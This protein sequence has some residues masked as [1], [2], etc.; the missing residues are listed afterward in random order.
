MRKLANRDAG[1]PKTLDAIVAPGRISALRATIEKLKLEKLDLETALLTSNEHNDYLQDHLYRISTSLAAEVRERQVVE[2][3]LQQVLQEVAEENV[4]LENLVQI[5]IDQGDASAEE[6]A[7]ARIDGLTQIAN[8]RRFDEYLWHEWGRHRQA[9]QPIS[10]LICDV[11]HFKL[12]NDTYGHQAGD[13]CLR[14]VAKAM[15]LCVRRNADVV[16]RYGG[17]EFAMVLPETDLQGAVQVANRVR[18]ALELAALSYA[19][20][21]VSDKV[22]LSIG[23]ACRIPDPQGTAGPQVLL[24]EADRFLY[25]AKHH[26]RN[27]VGHPGQK[28]VSDHHEQPDTW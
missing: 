6:G 4:D 3:K 26:G 25:L 14:A 10:L 7:K 19:A 8:R 24:E 15:R 22:T 28:S 18:A 23:A 2:R 1:S 21:P 11:D 16:A 12:F 9:Q 13:D 5:L 20:S 27:R 17:E